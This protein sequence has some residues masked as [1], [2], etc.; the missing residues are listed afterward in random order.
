MNRVR[1][2]SRGTQKRLFIQFIVANLR[3]LCIKK[4]YKLSIFL[5]EF[6]SYMT[7]PRETLLIFTYQF[8]CP[9]FVS[10]H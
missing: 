10:L 7:V 2:I 4:N 5:I 1:A 8:F 6:S 3:D 9:F